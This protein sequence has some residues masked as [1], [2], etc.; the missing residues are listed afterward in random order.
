MFKKEFIKMID[1]LNQLNEKH[2][3]RNPKVSVKYIPESELYNKNKKRKKIS[4]YSSI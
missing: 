4:E 1:Q 2:I 3:N